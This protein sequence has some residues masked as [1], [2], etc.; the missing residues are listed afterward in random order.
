MVGG[1]A[2]SRAQASSPSGGAIGSSTA[3]SPPDSTHVDVTGGSQVESPDQS[4]WSMR[5][6]QR[7][8]VD[9]L[10]AVRDQRQVAVLVRQ[11]RLGAGDVLGE[12]LAVREGDEEVGAAVQDQDRNG[13]L[14]DLES[15]GLDEGQVVVDPTVDTVGD[16]AL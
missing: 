8:L 9:G 7:P 3:T 15:P 16:R 2:S 13:D 10:D 4:G 6:I 5:Q 14:G 1:C 12:P 11:P